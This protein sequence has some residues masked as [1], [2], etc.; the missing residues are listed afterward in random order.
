M[1]NLDK[2]EEPA[3]KPA[4]KAEAAPAAK[5]KVYQDGIHLIR[6]DGTAKPKPKVY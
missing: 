2:K 5:P 6:D 1:I 3:S 4:A